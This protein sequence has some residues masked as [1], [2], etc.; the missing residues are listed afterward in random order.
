MTI[1]IYILEWILSF[2]IL[3]VLYFFVEKL[4]K[5]KFNPITSYIFTFI[6]LS[7]FCFLTVPYVISFPKPSLIYFPFLIFFLIY[8]IFKI[9]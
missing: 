9:K 1:L 5:K 3:L 8:S 6:V 2:F 4:F 7:I